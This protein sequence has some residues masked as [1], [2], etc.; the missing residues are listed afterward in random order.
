MKPIFELKIWVTKTQ[1]KKIP[2]MASIKKGKDI[3]TEI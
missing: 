2:M 1:N 3:C